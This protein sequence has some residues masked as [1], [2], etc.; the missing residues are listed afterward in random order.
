ML[1]LLVICAIVGFVA[2]LLVTYVPMTAGSKKLIRI[3]AV[4]AIILILCQAFGIFN[5]IRDVP[6]PQVR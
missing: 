2:W 4:V 6:V 5:L 1:H 3:A